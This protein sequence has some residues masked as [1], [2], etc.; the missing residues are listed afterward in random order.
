MEIPRTFGRDQS[1][2]LS[3]KNVLVSR[4]GKVRPIENQLSNATTPMPKRTHQDIAINKEPIICELKTIL[5]RICVK[6]VSHTRHEP[7]WDYLVNT[8]HYLGY[9]KL[10]GHRLKYLAF[11]NERPIAAFAWSA[12]ALKLRC[13]DN[14]IGWSPEQR[15]THLKRIANNSRFLI[16][17]W[18]QVP[19]L[20]S[21]VLSRCV[22]QL[23]TDWLEYF[24]YHLWCLE[25]FV[26]PQRFKATSYKAAN[27]Q[28]L[29]YTHGS[30]KQGLGYKYHG[31]IKEVYFYVLDSQFRKHIG[32]RRSD[33]ADRPPLKTEK[34]EELH[35]L[36]QH[37]DWNP[38][39]M[40]G[41]EL[42]E[43]DVA[44]MAEELVAFHQ[45]F[46]SCFGRSEH[47]R[48]GLAYLS[49]LL[50]NCKA[51]S[52]EPIALE[53]LGQDAVRSQQRFMKTYRWNLEAMENRHLNMLSESISCP[54]GMINVDSSEFVKKG[55]ESVGVA[56]QYCG[57]A[58]KVE[59]CQSG[60]F[61]GYSSKMSI[62]V[63]VSTCSSP[64]F[65]VVPVE[66]FQ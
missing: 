56:R 17:S 26:N 25:T 34:M 22:R 32:C 18:V 29:G 50:S 33:P 5:P 12:P 11:M 31:V 45:E 3:K 27:W 40:P 8:Y 48:L 14:F 54:K 19:H 65:P 47:Q 16:P 24:N 44:D 21:H 36:L 51:K 64:K 13:R 46:H 42:S 61:V 9:R 10:L 62:P 41:M 30:T 39:V 63:K 55:K 15:K 7:L 58:G 4:T 38:D 1:C 57:E 53:F 37:A 28:F 2:L 43:Q 52:I 35:M 6:M 60:V 20:A 66:G 59:N 23:E 49:G